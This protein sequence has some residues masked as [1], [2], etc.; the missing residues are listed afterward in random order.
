VVPSI[1]SKEMVSLLPS[2]LGLEPGTKVLIPSMAYP[3]YDAGA[4]LAGCE[5]VP[6]DDPTAATRTASGWSG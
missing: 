1:G 4:R 5:P 3:T 6:V 2:F